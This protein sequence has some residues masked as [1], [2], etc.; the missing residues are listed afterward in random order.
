MMS[1]LETGLGD[2]DPGGVKDALA[3]MIP[4][5]RYG[6]PEEVATLVAFLAS[7]DARYINGSIMT[8]DGG[9]TVG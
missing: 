5:G 8:V 3:G 2:G 1:S 7:E 4:M 9:F 6:T